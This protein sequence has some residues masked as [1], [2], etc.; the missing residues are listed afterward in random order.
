MGGA[1]FQHRGQGFGAYERRVTVQHDRLALGLGQKGGCL[2]HG[3]GGAQLGV[4]QNSLVSLVKGVGCFGH[5]LGLVPCH[6]HHARGFQRPRR[7]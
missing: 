4:L 7:T 5:G 3:V 6:H 2:G 1:G